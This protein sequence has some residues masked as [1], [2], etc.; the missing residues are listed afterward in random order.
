MV[1]C[2]GSSLGNYLA[3][4]NEGIG[5]SQQDA[6]LIFSFAQLGALI[7]IPFACLLGDKWGY[8][9]TLLSVSVICFLSTL[10]AFYVRDLDLLSII[11]FITKGSIVAFVTLIYS[12]VARCCTK[13]NIAYGMSLISIISSISS[14]ITPLSLGF[15]MNRFGN[16]SFLCWNA[17]G[18]LLTLILMTFQVKRLQ[19]EGVQNS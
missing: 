18:I 9:K 3:I 5:L 1:S 2:L 15:L 13:E 19:R 16:E 17:L 4:F 12:W 7:F 10:G 6:A 8:E 11:F 14:F